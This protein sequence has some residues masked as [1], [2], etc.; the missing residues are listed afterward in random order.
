MRAS[1]MLPSGTYNLILTPEDLAKLRD[2]GTVSLRI[3]RTPCVTAR[4]V[5]DSE[6]KDIIRKDKKDI[7]NDLRFRLNDPVDDMGPG[8]YNVQYLN[9]V[10]EEPE[11]E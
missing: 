3:S 8:L 1:Y 9:I 6:K 11:D 4:D 10:L 2:T 5:W 7:F